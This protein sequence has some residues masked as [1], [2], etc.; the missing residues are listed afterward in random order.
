MMVVLEVVVVVVVVVVVKCR[1]FKRFCILYIFP[2]RQRFTTAV[3]SLTLAEPST[4]GL[5]FW[6]RAK[7][8]TL[9]LLLDGREIFNIGK[10]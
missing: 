6:V 7:D 3:R 5:G 9:S 2:R 10:T 8:Q 1:I 4:L